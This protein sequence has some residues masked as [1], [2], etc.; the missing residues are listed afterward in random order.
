MLET[1]LTRR[2]ASVLTKITLKTLIS[3]GLIALA[4]VL[5][6]VVHIHGSYHF[7]NSR[8]ALRPL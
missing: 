5:P 3:A 8:I 2:S 1:A 4:V 7:I 6:Q